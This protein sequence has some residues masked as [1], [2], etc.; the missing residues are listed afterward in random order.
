MASLKLCPLF[1]DT[2]SIRSL[3]V[4]SIYPDRKMVSTKAVK[5]IVRLY[6]FSCAADG[7]GVY[8]KWLLIIDNRLFRTFLTGRA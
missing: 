6:L 3:S 8:T 4:K 7:N 2:Y 1:A 5:G